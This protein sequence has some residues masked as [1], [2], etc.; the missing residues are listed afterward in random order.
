MVKSSVTIQ[1]DPAITFQI[2]TDFAQYMEWYPECEA[3]SVIGTTGTN[4]DINLQLGGMKVARMVLRYDCRPNTSVTYHMV[5]SNDLKGFTGGYQIVDAGNGSHVV[6]ME[7]DLTASVPKFVTD[8]MMKSS[9]EKQGKQLLQRNARFSA[10]GGAAAIASGSPSGAASVATVASAPASRAAQAKRP[11]CL[12]RV[13]K[14]GEGVKIWYAG[15]E[16]QQSK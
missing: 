11:R 13:R 2:L 14:S 4:T 12:L 8:R 10:A 1:G 5:S 15:A 7:V 16:F 3:I 9:L 6:N